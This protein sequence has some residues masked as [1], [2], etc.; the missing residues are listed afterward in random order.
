MWCIILQGVWSTV[1]SRERGKMWLEIELSTGKFGQNPRRHILIKWLDT[2][3]C[4]TL[5]HT[6]AYY[7]A[8]KQKHL[9]KSG[10]THCTT[11][12][13]TAPRCN[14]LHHTAPH[15]ITL[16]HTAAH[17]NTSNKTLH[18]EELARQVARHRQT[19]KS[20]TG[21]MLNTIYSYLYHVKQ[22]FWALYVDR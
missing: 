21:T 5:Q 12:H 6:V 1:C 9:D 14:T 17:R 3:H 15:C 13:H 19:D 2:P 18:F 4:K 10:L 11:L 22:G 8:S 7:S 16:Q 20:K